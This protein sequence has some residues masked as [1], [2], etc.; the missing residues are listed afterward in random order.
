MVFG[1]ATS[2]HRDYVKWVAEAPFTCPD[3]GIID[4]VLG[5]AFVVVKSAYEVN[6]RQI[7]LF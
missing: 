1:N 5:S 2:S 7:S 3:T 4:N 6:G